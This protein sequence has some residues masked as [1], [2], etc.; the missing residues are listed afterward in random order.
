MP[1][2][3]CE[4]NVHHHQ[5]RRDWYAR[6]PKSLRLREDDLLDSSTSSSPNASSARTR[7]AALGSEA[8]PF[9]AFNLELRY[10]LDRHEVLISITVKEDNV[11]AIKALT[12]E[13]AAPPEGETANDYRSLLIGAPCR[14]R[15]CAPGSGGR[16]SIP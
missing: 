6:H 7:V 13:I 12:D 2:Y 9:E 8:Q 14:I 11:P 15:T 10:R 5:Q 1:Y 3:A 4:P 16:C